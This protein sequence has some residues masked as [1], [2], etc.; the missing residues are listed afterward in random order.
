MACPSITSVKFGDVG[1]ASQ[2][3]E[4]GDYIF[5]AS[6]AISSCEA[7]ITSDRQQYWT[8]N[9]EPNFK[10]PDDG[11]TKVTVSY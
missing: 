10:L 11:A 2:L 4:C 1:L 9:L 8:N 5:N 7:Y 6:S 3:N